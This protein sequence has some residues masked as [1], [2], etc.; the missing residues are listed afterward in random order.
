MTRTPARARGRHH[1]TGNDSRRKS[2]EK[3]PWSVRRLDFCTIALQ[4]C[5][6][7]ALQAMSSIFLERAGVG[8]TMVVPQEEHTVAAQILGEESHIMTSS[9]VKERNRIVHKYCSS[10]TVEC[11]LVKCL[12]CWFLAHAGSQN[13]S[14]RCS[15]HVFVLSSCVEN[16]EGNTVFLRFVS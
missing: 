9:I 6:V 14:R 5:Q 7:R 1:H 3:S 15:S 8:S 4:L 12:A 2:E 10:W 16:R 13:P 11:L